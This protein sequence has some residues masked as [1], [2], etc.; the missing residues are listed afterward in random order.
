MG[1]TVGVEAG[2]IFQLQAEYK[3]EVKASSLERRKEKLRL[4]RAEILTRASDIQAALTQDLGKP[5][6]ESAG[7]VES[8]KKAIDQALENLDAWAQPVRLEPSP[9]FEGSEPMIACEARGVCLIFGPWNLPFQLLFEP[10]VPAIAAGNT[11]ILKPNEVTPAAARVSVDIVRAVFDEREVAIFEGGVDVANILLDLPVDHIFFTGSP[12]VGKVVMAAAAKHLATVTLE[13]GGKCPA[14][15]DG[16]HDVA[17]SARLVAVGRHMNGGQVCLA[18]D[19]VWVRSEVTEQFLKH[20]NAWIDEHLYRDGRLDPTATSHIVD[21]RNMARVLSYLDDAKER[22]ATIVRGGDRSPI[23]D[24]MI[25]PT[26]IADA[27]VDSQVMTQ[28]IFAPVLPV[29]TFTDADEIIGY[30]RQRPKP[31]AIYVFSDD[32]NFI[33]R[34]LQGTS[35]GGATINGFA[36][37]I[38]ESRLPFG[39]VNHSGMGRYHGIHGFKEFSHQRSIVHHVTTSRS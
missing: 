16:T 7:E 17:E 30:V 8:V 1:S 2:R 12:A 37:H 13:L 36:T 19:H 25:E 35:S 11:A 32:T 5:A 29:Q 21:E 39:G 6:G 33:D 10:L 20:Y 18:P 26:I 24:D 27:P 38:A 34:I 14:I 15:V 28:E 31:L 23:V 4:L 9:E 3:W 22:K